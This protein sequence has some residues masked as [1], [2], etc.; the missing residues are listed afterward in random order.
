M[1]D[2]INHIRYMMEIK[3]WQVEELLLLVVPKNRP[4]AI[5]VIAVQLRSSTRKISVFSI[6]LRFIEWQE[7]GT[8]DNRA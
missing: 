2:L 8:I 6:G 1:K 7:D 3:Y 5:D 4:Y